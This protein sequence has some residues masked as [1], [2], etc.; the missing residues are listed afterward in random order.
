MA[1][2]RTAVAPRG[3]AMEPRARRASQRDL[4]T[5]AANPSAVFFYV[6]RLRRGCERRVLVAGVEGQESRSR[7]RFESAEDG[8]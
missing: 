3:A 2:R 8:A 1:P 6:V 7:E 4:R 5:Q